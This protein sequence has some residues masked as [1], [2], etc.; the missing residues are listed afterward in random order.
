MNIGVVVFPGSNCDHDCAYIFK[1]VL[2]QVCGDGLA[3]KTLLP[4]LDAIVL[5]GG[6]S[7]GDYLRTGDCAIFSG[8]D[9]AVK[10]FANKGRPGE[11]ASAT[12]FKSPP[13]P[14][15]TRCDAAAQHVLNFPS[16]RDAC[17]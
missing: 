7:Y 14:V 4:G 1:D 10:A 13:R 5:P 3:P 12:V 8:G 16:A 6:F 9:E 2:G 11:S 17:M 15:V